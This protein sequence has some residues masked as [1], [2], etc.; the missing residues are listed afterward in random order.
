MIDVKLEITNLLDPFYKTLNATYAITR[1][2]FR[3]GIADYLDSQTKSIYLTNTFFHRYEKVRLLDVYQSLV[4]YNSNH[5]TNFYDLAESF[6]VSNY[7]ALTG[8]A[9]SGKSM[10]VKFIALNAIKQK[11]RIPVLVHLRQFNHINES[12]TDHIIN[13]LYNCGLKSNE[14]LI[15]A[16]LQ[17]GAFLFIFDGFDEIARSRKPSVQHQIV[18]FIEMF[19]KNLFIVTSRPGGGVERLSYFINYKIKSL[20]KNDILLLIGKTI[21]KGYLKKKIISDLM[22]LHRESKTYDLFRSYLSNPLLLSM[23]LRTISYFPELPSHKQVFY[24][25]IF[26]TLYS[27]HDAINND[28]LNRERVSG[29]N[30]LEIEKFLSAFCY[31]TYFKQL[32]VFKPHEVTSLIRQVLDKL[33]YSVDESN[34]LY[35]LNTTIGVFLHDGP[36]YTFPHRS[37]QEYFCALFISSLSEDK[38]KEVYSRYRNI[39][40]EEDLG[41]DYNFWE[42][43]GELDPVSFNESFILPILA[44]IEEGLRG[45]N[46]LNDFIGYFEIT[47]R[48]TIEKITSIQSLFRNISDSQIENIDELSES[49]VMEKIGEECIVDEGT[50][51]YE[52]VLSRLTK[53]TE[54]K[55]LDPQN[56]YFVYCSSTHLYELAVNSENLSYKILRFL[57]LDPC[58]AITSILNEN[59][60]FRYNL[61]VV[62]NSISASESTQLITNQISFDDLSNQVD[63]DIGI[64]EL[65][66]SNLLQISLK[67]TAI[68]AAKVKQ[69]FSIDELL[70]L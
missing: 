22:I 7:I 53:D 41:G 4:A 15:R 51:E 33:S 43:C 66:E 27:H 28:G 60:D 20:S 5:H 34:V 64:S 39:V 63:I 3:L 47:P 18:E 16:D 38:K 48:K 14:Q 61:G 37:L 56:E 36:D 65:I 8:R 40:N 6:K 2:F 19:H 31:V 26:E 62:M 67:S 45:V 49:D 12:V 35:D 11:F 25:N 44:G 10:L 57:G 32:L 1:D 29:L 46:E 23:F 24:K 21:S 70:N 52:E 68:R 59:H 58:E 42:L 9:G 50:E 54:G 69:A 13:K 30:R 17:K 55:Y